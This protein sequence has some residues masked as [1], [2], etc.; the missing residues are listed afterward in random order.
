MVNDAKGIEY[1]IDTGGWVRYMQAVS[2]TPGS[3]ITWRA[4]DVNGDAEATQSLTG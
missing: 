1:R 4:V 3:T 2:V